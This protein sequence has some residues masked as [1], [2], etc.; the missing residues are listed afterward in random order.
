MLIPVTQDRFFGANLSLRTGG[1]FAPARL[2]KDGE[3]LV[4][5]AGIYNVTDK[6]G[7][8]ARVTLKRR[9]FDPV[10]RVFIDGAEVFL[11][12]PLTWPEMA[13]LGAP[14]LLVAQGGLIGV[15]I[16]IPALYVSARVFRGQ[17]RTARKY[18]LTGLIGSGAVLLHMI[19]GIG[20]L[21]MAGGLGGGAK[22]RAGFDAGAALQSRLNDIRHLQEIQ[23]P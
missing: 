5:E 9:I 11:M 18:L 22:G 7:A 8:V 2:L 21:L 20:F 17:N 1:W 23:G 13:W 4:P 15:A 14:A 19:F 12:P 6:T 10:P 3:P 16:G